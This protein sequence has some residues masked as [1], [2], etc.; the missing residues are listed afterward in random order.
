MTESALHTFTADT[1]GSNKVIEQ[2]LSIGNCT[3]T[4]GYLC[5]MC[6]QP[7]NVFYRIEMLMTFIEECG[8]VCRLE[9]RRF[10]FDKTYAVYLMLL[11]A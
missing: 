2:L 5:L 8:F 7:F 3:F 1:C 9:K 4:I 6:Q 10:V 11:I